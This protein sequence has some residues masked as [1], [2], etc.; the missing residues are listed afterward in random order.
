MAGAKTVLT[1]K[2]VL[3]IALHRNCFEPDSILILNDTLR[4]AKGAQ[5]VGSTVI[6]KAGRLPRLI[7]FRPP[8]LDFLKSRTNGPT[9]RSRFLKRNHPSFHRRRSRRSLRAISCS[10]ILS[11]SYDSVIEKKSQ[12]GLQKFPDHRKYIRAK[13]GSSGGW[14]IA[15]NEKSKQSRTGQEIDSADDLARLRV[16]EPSPICLAALPYDLD[17][18]FRTESSHFRSWRQ[19]IVCLWLRRHYRDASDGGGTTK[20]LPDRRPSRSTSTSTSWPFRSRTLTI[21]LSCA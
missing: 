1:Q 12:S 16:D 8:V 19:E 5:A 6:I 7:P 2:E 11:L 4:V 13:Q 10:R 15:I 21:K 14:V 17:L 3:S 18:G 9:N 20:L